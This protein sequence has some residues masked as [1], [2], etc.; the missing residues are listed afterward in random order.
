MEEARRVIERLRRIELLDA[1]GA[2]PGRLLPELRALVDEA[3]RW[4][5]AESGGLDGAVPALARCR[6]S[7]ERADE[8]VPV[9]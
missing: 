6:A 4:L 9:R 5:D 2:E 8:V 3:E 7:L 1:G